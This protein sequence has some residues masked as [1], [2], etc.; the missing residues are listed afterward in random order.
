MVTTIE[1]FEDDWYVDGNSQDPLV[2]GQPQM[3]GETKCKCR[4]SLISTA[5]KNF[6]RQHF[7]IFF[8]FVQIVSN[9]DNVHELSNPISSGKNKSSGPS[10]S[11]LMM[12]LVNDSLKFTSSDTRI[13]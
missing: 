10:C 7:E 6:S 3:V 9:R 2:D 13:C 8:L 1:F 12:L 5:G 4:N 11:K